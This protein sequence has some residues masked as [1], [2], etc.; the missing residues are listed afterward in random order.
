LGDREGEEIILQQKNPLMS[1]FFDYS[2]CLVKHQSFGVLQDDV[3][4]SESLSG[5]A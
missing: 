5:I 1:G 3:I 4:Q 2:T